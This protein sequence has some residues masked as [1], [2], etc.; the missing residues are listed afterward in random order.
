MKKVSIII[1]IYNVEKYLH[2]CIESVESQT[3]ENIEVILVNDGSTDNSEIIIEKFKEKY[4]NIKYI[5]KENGG[6]SDARN[7]GI[8]NATG[9]YI[10]FVD[11]DDYISDTLLNDLSV[12]MEQEYDLIKFK[13]IKV[14]ENYKEI[15]KVEGP[16][17]EN[18]NGEEAFNLLYGNDVM[19]QPAWLYL[20]KKSFWDRNKFEYP[21]GMNHEDFARTALIMLKADSVAST[22]VYGYYYVQ[23]EGSIT[24]GNDETK[25]LKRAQDI[26]NHYDYMLRVIDDYNIM[27]RTKD[28]LKIYY[29]NCMILKL[30]E[31]SE[32]SKKVYLKELKERKV[33]KNIKVRSPKQLI[34]KILLNINVDW[35]LKLR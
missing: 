30:D 27:K 26:I 13:M 32:E 7:V 34:K 31:L 4:N 24:R 11:S 9:D 10:L 16:I 15:G 33:F 23:S 19:L 35:Y 6:L 5:K 21:V 17:F 28:N 18:K 12:Y 1:P 8:R 14:D 22:N 3:L 20:Y 25:K 2:K 29:T